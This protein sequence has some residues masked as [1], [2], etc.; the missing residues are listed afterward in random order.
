MKFSTIFSLATETNAE[1]QHWWKNK[2]KT[3]QQSKKKT[4]SNDCNI[5]PFYEIV[6]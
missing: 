5:I 4:L 1:Y 6:L 2:T 3:K